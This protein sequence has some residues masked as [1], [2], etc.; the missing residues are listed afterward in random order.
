MRSKLAIILLLILS[1]AAL[2]FETVQIGESGEA[3]SVRIISSDIDRSVIEYSF[4]DYSWDEVSI[5][6]KKYKLLQNS[7]KESMIMDAGY[8][9]LPRINRSLRIPDNGIMGY[10]VITAEYIELTDVDIAPSKGHLLRSV[11][12]E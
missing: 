6:G 1:H 11:D 8:P 2:S 12:A 7:P 10:E 9:Q 3:S 4:A 5:G